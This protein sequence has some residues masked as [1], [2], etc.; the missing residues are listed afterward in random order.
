MKISGD[1]LIVAIVIVIMLAVYAFT[2]AVFL[3]QL[4]TLSVGGLLGLAKAQQGDSKAVAVS[5]SDADKPPKL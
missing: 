1:M 2:K 4:L 5:M 3:E